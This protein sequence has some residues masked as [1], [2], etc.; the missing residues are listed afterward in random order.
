[1]DDFH[2]RRFVNNLDATLNAA[3]ER[4][5]KA[6][7]PKPRGPTSCSTCRWRLVEMV[8]GQRAVFCTANGLE[9]GQGVRLRES[10]TRVGCPKHEPLTLPAP[11]AKAAPDGDAGG[12]QQG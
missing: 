12:G 9:T 5:E 2:L 1:M 11:G 3:I 8:Y 6:L 10:M 4:L 7:T